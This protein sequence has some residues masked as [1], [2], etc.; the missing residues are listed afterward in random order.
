MKIS[1]NVVWRLLRRN[2]SPWQIIGYAAANLIGLTIVLTAVQFYRDFDAGQGSGDDDDGLLT[3]DFMIISKKVS[4]LN[5]LGAGNTSFDA[6]DLDELRAQPWARRVGEFRSADF[7]VYAS[8]RLGGRGMSTY[9]FFESIPDEFFDIKPSGWDFDPADPVIPIVLSKDYLTLYNFGFAATRGLPQLSEDVI[10]K[11]PLKMRL[12]GKG[13]TGTYDARIVGFSSRLNT[14]AVPEAVMQ[15]ADSLYSEPLE[16]TDGPSRVI[17]EVTKPGD[18]VITDFLDS[19]GYEVAGD[20]AGSSR[21]AFI[22]NL[23]TAIVIAIGS[24][25]TLLAFFILTLSL[26]LLLQ[27][28]RAKLHDLML[29]GYTPTSVARYYYMLVAAVNLCVFVAALILTAIAAHL[30]QSSMGTLQVPPAPFWPT[31][32]V[33]LAIMLVITHLNILSVRRIV[34][35]AF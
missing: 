22:F 12:S 5:T 9:L 18:P 32:F 15:W 35:R 21:A 1:A 13:N 20:K 24:V 16:K 14:I 7:N 23:V 33:G 28:N 27:K 25:I 11:V 26:Y 17:L 31:A 29:L 19:R 3:N 6:G 30:W 8:L 2:I 10:T 4:L 34:R